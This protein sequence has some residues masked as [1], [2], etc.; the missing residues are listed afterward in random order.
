LWKTDTRLPLRASESGWRKVKRSEKIGGLRKNAGRLSFSGLAKSFLPFR[1]CGPDHRQ[2][3]ADGPCYRFQA[4]SYDCRQAL[5]P[6]V[7]KAWLLPFAALIDRAIRRANSSHFP[8]PASAAVS[9]CSN[10]LPQTCHRYGSWLLAAWLSGLLA[11]AGCSNLASQASNVEGVRLYQQGNYQQASDRF[12][13]AIAEDPT[14]P[15]GY[16]NLAA[17]LHKTGTLYNRPHDLQQA[18]HLY[19]QC[20]QRDPNHTECYRGLAVLLSESGRTDQAFK[21][22]ESWVASSPQ[23]A[24]AKIELARLHEEFNHTEQAKSRLVE[25]LA[26]DPHNARALTALGRLRDKEGDHA[27]ALSNYQRSLQLDRFQPQV[28]SRVTT[29]LGAGGAATVAA[30]PQPNATRLAN[31]SPNSMRY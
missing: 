23:S 14:S 11:C 17:A 16:Y 7:A 1:L 4:L 21:L 10:Q 2:S 5:P 12:Q 18:E 29:L 19:N 3:S 31:P 26:G 8:D 28:A 24:D 27:Q 9:I 30:Q 13:R 15:G 20:L 22:M 6:C 25:A